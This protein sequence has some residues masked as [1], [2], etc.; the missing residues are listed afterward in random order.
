MRWPV[1][2]PGSYATKRYLKACEEV[3]FLSGRRFDLQGQPLHPAV[4][5]PLHGRR[6]QHNYSTVAVDIG[7][8]NSETEVP[9]VTKRAT[10][11]RI[12]QASKGNDVEGILQAVRDHGE[13][14]IGPVCAATATH[15]L[16]KA[17]R[18]RRQHLRGPLRERCLVELR[19]PLL[20]SLHEFG[21][22]A[23]AN[24]FWALATLSSEDEELLGK[25]SSAAT[26]KITQFQGRHL[27]NVC[28]SLA[29]LQHSDDE[30]LKTLSEE[31]PVRARASEFT[32]QSLANILWSYATLS[33]WNAGVFEGHAEAVQHL[34]MSFNAQDLSNTLWALTSYPGTER[35]TDNA[36]S[37]SRIFGSS[38]GGETLLVALA[39]AAKLQA[40]GLR[41]QDLSS[42]AWAFADCSI[43]PA[44]RCRYTERNASKNGIERRTDLK[45]EAVE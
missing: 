21:T 18:S 12:L 36:H 19:E 43:I 35:Q 34:A 33:E 20:L 28:W 30:L 32:P 11:D 7:T 38:P 5:S 1:G 44:S 13:T 8:R 9:R 27:S 39:A 2:N 16:A 3:I 4:V 42:I 40:S 10:Q 37:S 31:I 25:L 29:T 41:P 22:Q 24:T 6:L 15:R 14:Y 26:V 23:I 45:Y 17:L